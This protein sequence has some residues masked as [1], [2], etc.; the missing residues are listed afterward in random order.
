MIEDCKQK[1]YNFDFKKIEFI[2]LTN[3]FCKSLTD[4]H[5]RP[6]KF[7]WEDS[8]DIFGCNFDICWNSI[9]DKSLQKGQAQ[10]YSNNVDDEHDKFVILSLMLNL[11]VHAILVTRS[12]ATHGQCVYNHINWADASVHVGNITL[13][14]PLPTIF[15]SNQH[16][17]NPI[18]GPMELLIHS[19]PNTV[20]LVLRHGP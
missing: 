14:Q 10:F 18:K 6:L 20:L 12:M 1:H 5:I 2:S 4:G 3:N 17:Y 11:W 9:T 16:N 13:K 7:R 15:S 8:D 19:I